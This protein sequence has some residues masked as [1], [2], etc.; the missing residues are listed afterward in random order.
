[1]NC[2]VSPLA[3]F[4][5]PYILGTVVEPNDHGSC[6]QLR[7]K[8]SVF[9]PN[10]YFEKIQIFCGTFLTGGQFN[11]TEALHSILAFLEAFF[12][13]NIVIKASYAY[14]SY[15]QYIR[16]TFGVGWP[17]LSGRGSI[18]AFISRLP[19]RRCRPT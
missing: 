10:W 9:S 6:W 5:E 7:L 11:I 2:L 16:H 1:M 14:W 19:R 8:L 3:Q 18:Q 17:L 13:T 15:A 12:V 4:G